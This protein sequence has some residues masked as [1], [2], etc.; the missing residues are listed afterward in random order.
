MLNTVF[1]VSAFA[2][3][4]VSAQLVLK[5]WEVG[6]INLLV[7]SR[8]AVNAFVKSPNISLPSYKIM[9]IYSQLQA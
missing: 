2:A 4:A 9:C 5:T 1:V 6:F 3:K 7:C 8:V